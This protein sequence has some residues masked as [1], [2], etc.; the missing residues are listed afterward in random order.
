MVAAKTLA[1]VRR[2]ALPIRVDLNVAGAVVTRQAEPA[3]A[4]R[5]WR[6]P[7]GTN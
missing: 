7:V 6:L 1:T 4:P 2:L 3:P 5:P